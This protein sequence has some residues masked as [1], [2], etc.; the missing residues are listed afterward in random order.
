MRDSQEDYTCGGDGTHNVSLWFSG[1]VTHFGMHCVYAVGV[2]GHTLGVYKGIGRV[3]TNTASPQN[4]GNTIIG[5]V[6]HINCEQSSFYDILLV[7][8]EKR[9]FDCALVYESRE[10]I[11]WLYHV[12]GDCWI[13]GSLV[14]GKVCSEV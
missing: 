14:T 6:N 13:S 10:F 1:T 7:E 3:L 11:V 4:T 5:Y 12:F 2:G 8:K 9:L